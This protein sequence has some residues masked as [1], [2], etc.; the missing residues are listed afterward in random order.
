MNE[1]D[2]ILINAYLDG[3]TSDND[4]KYVELMLESNEEANEYANNIKRAN[5]EIS[6]YF[7]SSEFNDL[8]RNVDEFVEQQTLKSKKNWFS[9]NNFFNNPKYYGFA[10]SAF[11][12]A[13]I[14]VPTFNQNKFDDLPIYSI[15]SERSS[16]VNIDFTQIFNEAVLEYGE[17]SIWAFKIQS[18][19]ST[20]IIQIVDLKNDCYNGTVTREE[21]SDI[22]EFK[23]CKK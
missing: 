21:T 7:N 10:A 12:L 23:V 19:E 4:S 17:K 16:A 13:I 14:M 2:K 18:S 20:L 1:N 8:K 11:L 6:T 15:S 5:S 3:D 9:F 22:K